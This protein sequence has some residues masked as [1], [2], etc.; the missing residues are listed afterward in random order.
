MAELLKQKFKDWIFEDISRREFYVQ[1]YNRTFNNTRLREYHG[2]YLTFPGMNPCYELNPH[3]KNAVSR[4]LRG[5]TLLAH[6]VGA[7]KSFVM[8][9]E[10][11]KL[12]PSASVL[13]TTEKDFEKKNRQKFVSKIATGE[14]DAIVMGHS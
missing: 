10:F 4:I 3:Q 8:A 9:A 2:D 13:L 5:T 12:Y 6:C 1:Y 7:G 11:M 14:Y